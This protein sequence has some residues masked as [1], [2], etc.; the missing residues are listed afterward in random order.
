MAD[1]E[2]RSKNFAFNYQSDIFNQKTPVKP[3]FNYSH[4]GFQNNPPNKSSSNFL[5][6]DEHK[7]T[8]NPNSNHVKRTQ[9]IAPPKPKLHQNFTEKLYSNEP[10]QI[11]DNNRGQ[12]ETLFLGS[13]SGEEYKVKKEKIDEYNPNLYYKTKKPEQIKKEQT[14]G[15]SKTKSKPAIQRTK[16]NNKLNEDINTINKKLESVNVER[17]TNNEYNPKYDS[18]QNRVNML[19]SNIF[20][21][22]KIEQMNKNWGDKIKEINSSNREIKEKKNNFGKKS[23]LDKNAEKLPMNL[24]WR[25]TKTNLLF[26]NETNKEIMKKD[27]RQRKFKELYGSNPEIPKERVENN[28]KTN[29]RNLIEKKTKEMNPDYNE[30]KI[31][32]ISS[33]ISQIQGNQFLNESSRYKIKNKYDE[34]NNKIY[35]INSKDIN[36]EE[37]QRAF[38]Q[39]G[40][41]IYDVKEES[42][43]IFG[44]NKNNK[45]TFKIRDNE[46]DEEFNSKIK[47]IQND[48]KN[49]KRAEIK[50]FS[51]K[52]KN[53]IDLIPNSVK[54]NNTNINSIM[55][56]KNVD[57]TLQ[58]KTHS[59]PIENKKEQKVTEIFV[60]L[61][62][63]NETNII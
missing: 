5:S 50:V 56:N 63:K 61:K 47:N 13:Y 55:K 33:N 2:T 23:K 29:D 52:E 25:D 48:F 34:D 6:W 49:N 1:Q 14:F 43:A 8:N 30:A 3:V 15:E 38:A 16:L 42:D 36:K 57:K 35:E 20:N 41:K 54:W 39:R 9:N 53:K 51:Q 21:D 37:I 44:N 60:N 58:E 7:S 17:S 32:M 11:I 4:K 46:Y 18:K 31:K 27:A 22:K 26:N 12:K 24:D 10:K 40:I 19:K 45:I 59:K 28:F 62:Y